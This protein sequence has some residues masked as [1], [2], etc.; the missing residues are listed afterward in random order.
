MKVGTDKIP[1]ADY[2]LPMEVAGV[3]FRNPFVVGSGPTVKTVD[4]LR[5]IERTGWG[6]AS[7]KLAIDPKY[8]SLPPR[9]RWLKKEKYHAFTAETRLMF[10]ESLRLIEQGRKVTKDLVIYANFAY[11]GTEGDEGWIRM[12]KQFEAAGAH[13]LELNMCCPNMSFNVV[14]SG[15]KMV[16]LSG[17]SVGSNAEV[18]SKTAKAIKDAVNIPVFVKLTPEGGKVGDVAKACFDLGIVSVG[19]TGNRLAIPEFDINNPGNGIC[20]LQDEPTLACFSGPWLKPLALRDVYEMRMKS[21]PVPNIMGSGGIEN[22]VDSVQM[23]MC[24]A[25]M[26]QIC[27]ATMTKGFGI[28]PN[29]VKNIKKFMDEKGYKS[30]LD[31][32]DLT[33]KKI[34]GANGLHLHSGVAVVDMNK[35]TGCGACEKIGHCYAIT[36]KDKKAIIEPEKCTGCAECTDVCNFAAITMKDTGEI[37]TLAK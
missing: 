24:G 1:E 30:Y 18:V 26:I 21:G 17:A 23:M 34:T 33:A 7:V 15:G 10:D 27:T 25:D 37:I 36:I 12:A 16:T 8:I 32:R 35:C 14:T 20:H 19:T 4:M 9:Y 2:L 28:L 31:F 13:V 6:G 3:K 29:I 22:W 11:A 5:E